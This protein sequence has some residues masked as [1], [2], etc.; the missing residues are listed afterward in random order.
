MKHIDI[1][2]QPRIGVARALSLTINGM[3]HRMLRST[4]TIVVIA[5]AIAFMMN[6]LSENIIK[7]HV[8]LDTGERIASMRMGVNWKARLSSPG[9]VEQIIDDTA[10]AATGSPLDIETQKLGGLDDAQMQSFRVRAAAAVIYKRWLD[11]LSY[12]PRRRLVHNAV[13]IEVFD[14]LADPQAM[15]RFES[16]LAAMKS[17]RF[18]TDLEAFKQF[19]AD[20]TTTKAQAEQIRSGRQRAA[21][22]LAGSLN[23][24]SYFQA[25]ERPDGRFAQAARDVGFQFDPQTAAVVATQATRMR[26]TLML[27]KTLEQTK[28]RQ[29]VAAWFDM[30]PSEVDATTLW[31]LLRNEDRAVWFAARLEE[32]NAV[33][34]VL[35]PARLVELAR[36]KSQEIALMRAAHLGGTAD[37]PVMTR[38]M[39][40]LVLVS[41]IVCMVGITNAMLMSVTQRFREIAT[42]KCLGV[43][44]GFIA[45]TFIIEA[46]MLGVVGGI[47]GAAAGLLIGLGRMAA[48]FGRVLGDSIRYDDLLGAVLAAVV[49]GVILAAVATV[50]PAVKAAKLP[51]MEAM[52]IE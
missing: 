35:S 12:G 22:E 44:D 16:E 31:K 25:L 41:V 1:H 6:T 21:A 48:L 40:W 9:T 19:L 3:R 24:Q 29:N 7:R 38:R 15:A 30:L 17:L 18:V 20:W 50:L 37:Q 23:G 13:G 27:E 43:L 42:L 26:Q 4:V 47:I 32:H 5:V 2:D 14:R 49:V 33:D 10:A 11:E 28:V 52:R 45:M 51:P 46:C 36:L 8:A 34:E 39:R